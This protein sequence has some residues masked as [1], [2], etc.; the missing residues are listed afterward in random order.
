MSALFGD[1]YMQVLQSP[2]VY[3]IQKGQSDANNDKSFP[4]CHRMSKSVCNISA[5]PNRKMVA[6][7]ISEEKGMI[8]IMW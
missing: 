5:A 1:E 6:V 3:G 7:S 8:L 4:F 2:L